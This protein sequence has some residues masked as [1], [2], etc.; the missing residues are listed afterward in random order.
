[1]RRF[2]APLSLV[3]P[4]A[5]FQAQLVALGSLARSEDPPRLGS[6]NPPNI[7]HLVG[8]GETVKSEARCQ[9]MG[10]TGKASQVPERRRAHLGIP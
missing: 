7:S 10:K 6:Y 9:A 1:M 2:P 5:R 8:R 3:L 4:M